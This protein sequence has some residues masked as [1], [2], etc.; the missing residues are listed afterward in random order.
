M[1]NTSKYYRY[2][3]YSF[4]IEFDSGGNPVSGA[5]LRSNGSWMPIDF[6]WEIIIHNNITI[7]EEK[8][9]LLE[10]IKKFINLSKLSSD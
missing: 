7:S 1:P 2:K 5:I 6:G 4:S 3:G 8:A 9:F 10:G